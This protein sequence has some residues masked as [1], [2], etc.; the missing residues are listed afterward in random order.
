MTDSMVEI[1]QIVKHL[2]Y[3]SGQFVNQRIH[4]HKFHFQSKRKSTKGKEQLYRLGAIQNSLIRKDGLS[5]K[6]P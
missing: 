5:E 4:A 2:P 3:R 1:Q 6:S